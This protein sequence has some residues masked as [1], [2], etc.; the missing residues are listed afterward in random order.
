MWNEVP[1]IERIG[2]CSYLPAVGTYQTCLK[3]LDYWLQVLLNSQ[4]IWIWAAYALKRQLVITSSQRHL[5]PLLGAK[6]PRAI[7]IAAPGI[8]VLWRGP[9]IRLFVLGRYSVS[10]PESVPHNRA[11]LKFHFTSVW[12]ALSVSKPASVLFLPLFSLLPTCF[13][14]SYQLW[15]LWTIFLI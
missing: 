8:P 2:F 12:P 6:I 14:L 3:S 15:A 10:S 9:S 5:F 4:K 11:A 1:S 13:F 7:L